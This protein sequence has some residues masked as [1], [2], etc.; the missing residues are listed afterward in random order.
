MHP[1]P[2]KD[3]HLLITRIVLQLVSME[4]LAE[5]DKTT[6]EFLRQVS[7]DLRIVVEIPILHVGKVSPFP[8]HRGCAKDHSYPLIPQLIDD[9]CVEF[10]ELVRIRTRAG[11]GLVPDIVDADPN[12]HNIRLLRQHILVH[13]EIEI[14]YLI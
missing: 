14:I 11:G 9:G 12:D 2:R 8:N 7:Y 10:L 1:V 4:Y 13:T 5:V 3:P 6:L